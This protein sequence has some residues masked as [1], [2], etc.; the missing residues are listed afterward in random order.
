MSVAST[1]PSAQSLWLGLM[2]TP[3]L[4][5]RGMQRLR[6]QFQT[7]GAIF[8]ASLT[9]LESCQI[10]AG[11]AQHL[12]DGRSL[13]LGC[14]EAE[15]ARAA[16]VT[17]VTL[18][19]RGYPELLRE[20]YD[21]PPVLYVRGNVSALDTFG[22]AVVGTRR[23]TLY[24]RLMAERFGRD[25]A[26]QGLTIF[27]G[28]ARG[29]DAIGQK[30]CVE[31]GGITVAVLGSGVDVIYPRENRGLAEAIVKAGGALASEFP[32]GTA[33]A[34]QNFPIRNRI[35]SGLAL[36]V[37]VVEGGEVSGS[38]ITARMALEQNREVYG[39]PGMATQKQAW[40]PNALIKQGAK[41][42]TEV[43]DIIDELPSAVRV[44]LTA[45]KL[46][47]ESS[48]GPGGATASGAEAAPQ[49]GAVLGALR[50]DEATHVDEIVNRLQNKLSAPEILT[51]LFDL[52]LGGEIRQLPGKK[53]LRVS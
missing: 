15:R 36:G 23:P 45:L 20:I 3:G 26:R 8:A 6:E 11:V 22:I 34:P 49:M 43:V 10:T 42:A 17:I 5:Q 2:L 40:L 13:A 44:R 27:S 48:A 14:A 12:H 4:G 16:G 41:M 7:A 52:E 30:A 32:L 21:P 51:L 35:I 24:G 37:L 31:A 46:P 18:G 47:P 29:I 39:V 33:P 9:E 1:P 25:L 53:Y 50:V 28:L 38:R 19:D